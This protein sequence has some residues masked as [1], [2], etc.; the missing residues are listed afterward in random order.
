MKRIYWVESN[1]VTRPFIAGCMRQ[2]YGYCPDWTLKNSTLNTSM[3]NLVLDK[4]PETIEQSL[5]QFF[6]EIDSNDINNNY[7]DN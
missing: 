1:T 3:A 6:D 4:K 5:N 7:W 2:K